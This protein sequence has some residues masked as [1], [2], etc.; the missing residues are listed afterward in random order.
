MMNRYADKKLVLLA[1]VL[2]PEHSDDRIIVNEL[3]ELLKEKHKDRIIA[4]NNVMYPYEVRNLIQRS[5][6]VVSARMHP[7]VSSFQCGTPAVAL[8]YSTKFWGVIGERYGLGDYII[9]VRYSNYIEMRE[10]FVNLINRM[11][12]EYEQIEDRIKKNNELAVKNI[13]CALEEIRDLKEAC[14][15]RR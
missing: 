14:T 9:D 4:V 15:E 13:M 8:S 3:N 11:E 6:F 5:L 2:K 7:I 10:K 1:H 12:T